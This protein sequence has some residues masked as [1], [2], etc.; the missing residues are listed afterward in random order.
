MS[1][2]GLAGRRATLSNGYKLVQ[3]LNRVVKLS[4]HPSTL[5]TEIFR[6]PVH[7]VLFCLCLSSAEEAS[8]VSYF[9]L[10]SKCRLTRDDIRQRIP[11]SSLNNNKVVS[12]PALLILLRREIKVLIAYAVCH[13][14][15]RPRTLYETQRRRYQAIELTGMDRF[16]IYTSHPDTLLVA[17]H[18]AQMHLY[19]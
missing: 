15:F 19:L 6:C 5:E 1:G 14:P 13:A 10:R 11:K 18:D 12:W 9:R 7:Q 8:V 3:R 16:L 17:G 4:M 2:M